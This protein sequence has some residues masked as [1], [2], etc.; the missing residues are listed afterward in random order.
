MEPVTALGILSLILNIMCAALN[1]IRGIHLAEHSLQVTFSIQFESKD[2]RWKKQIWVHI[3]YK[4]IIH[5]VLKIEVKFLLLVLFFIVSWANKKLAL[6]YFFSWEAKGAAGILVR[7]GH[8]A[9]RTA[10]HAVALGT[11]RVPAG[12]GLFI[13]GKVWLSD[14]KIQA[15]FPRVELSH[16]L[17][18]IIQ[19][20][21]SLPV[22]LSKELYHYEVDLAAC[23]S[24]SSFLF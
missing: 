11:P 3:V 19:M 6:L 10:G 1:L 9:T 2:R 7:N 13:Q 21:T 18:Y 8:L 24:Q 22:S 16:T 15:L 14:F 12:A 23:S 4:V 5:Y 17:I 20:D